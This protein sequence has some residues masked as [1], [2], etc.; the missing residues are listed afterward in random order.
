MKV[1]IER[2]KHWDGGQFICDPERECCGKRINRLTTKGM[3]SC[4][5]KPFEI[6]Q[7]HSKMTPTDMIRF[8]TDPKP[9]VGDEL[10]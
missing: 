2:C 6:V 9:I 5:G 1:L 3:E 10:Y 4:L 7:S 8:L